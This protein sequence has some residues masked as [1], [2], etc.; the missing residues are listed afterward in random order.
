MVSIGE[1]SAKPGH[2]VTALFED[3]DGDIWFGGRQGIERLRDEMFAT[4][5]KA[6]GLPSEYIGPVYGDT[7]G[8]NGS[9]LQL[10]VFT[11]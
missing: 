9:R 11:G 2:A 5:L 4:Y 8:R 6:E 3:R 10:A 1:I 7:D